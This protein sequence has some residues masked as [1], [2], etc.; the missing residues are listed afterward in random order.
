MKA[1]RVLDLYA[2]FFDGDPVGPDEYVLSADEKPRVQARQRIHPSRP[3]RPGRRPL[4]V[5]SEYGRHGTWPTSPP[6]TSTGLK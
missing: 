6:T 4:L 3:V 5:E 1:G 2:R